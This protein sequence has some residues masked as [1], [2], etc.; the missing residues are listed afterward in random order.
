MTLGYDTIYGFQDIKDD[1]IIGVKS[2]SIKFKDEPKKFLYICYFFFML[3]IIFVGILM[4]F[5]IYYYLFSLIPL[6]HLFIFQ[7]RKLNFKSTSMCLE[8]IKSNNFLCLLVFIN[9]LIGKLI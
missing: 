8:K 9:I 2:T 4:K 3:S 5:K 1:E 7:V 6:I